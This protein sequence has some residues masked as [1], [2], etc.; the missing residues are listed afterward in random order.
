MK[1]TMTMF[2]AVALIVL[3]AGGC[4]DKVEP[5]AT[6]S[7]AIDRVRAGDLTFTLQILN[8]QG[9]PQAVFEEGENFQFQFIIEN[10]GDSKYQS[11]IP[12]Y[13]PTAND[14]FFTLYRKSK[15]S[16]GAANVGKY[17][18]IGNNYRDFKLLAFSG[19]SSIVYIIPW[20][21][22]EDSIY[23]MPTYK[24]QQPESFIDRKYIKT[25]ASPPLI[26]AGEYYTGF[27]IQHNE[28]DSVR[29]E[30]SFT[31]K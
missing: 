8:M 26:K 6:N 29:L 10:R 21:V 30:A 7:P 25:E 15:E 13:F 9:E 22:E 17:F 2:I 27:T 12:W 14:E 19:G 28:T 16:G 18:R 20:L 5:L 24:G 3:T 1:K 11:S 4:E 31:V 23:I